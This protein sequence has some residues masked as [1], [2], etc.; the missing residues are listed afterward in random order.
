MASILGHI[1]TRELCVRLHLNPIVTLDSLSVSDFGQV[2][3]PECFLR[4][5]MVLAKLAT[6]ASQRSGGEGIWLSPLQLRPQDAGHSL[7]A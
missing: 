4:G 5:Y 6:V 2:R 7:P 3:E 1:V